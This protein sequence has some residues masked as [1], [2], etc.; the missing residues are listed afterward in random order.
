[1]RDKITI[2]HYTEEAQ[3]PQTLDCQIYT[4]TR[5][6]HL[7]NFPCGPKLRQDCKTDETDFTDL[8]GL[9]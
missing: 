4:L 6:S 1:M 3:N 5:H 2:K 7:C 8:N 9:F